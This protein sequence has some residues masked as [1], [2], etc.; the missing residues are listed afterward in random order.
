MIY[1]LKGKNFPPEAV[2][3]YANYNSAAPGVLMQDEP[4]W[5]PL[6]QEHTLE[7]PQ[8]EETGTGGYLY[9]ICRDA[10]GVSIETPSG[11]ANRDAWRVYMPLE[12]GSWTFDWATGKVS[13][14]LPSW[15]LP[16]GLIA[17]AALLGGWLLKKKR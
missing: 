6:G 16:T 17:G 14:R 11:A 15:V 1:K 8:G 4:L 12:G 9:V 5:K 10:S 7:F 13:K 3:W 2:M